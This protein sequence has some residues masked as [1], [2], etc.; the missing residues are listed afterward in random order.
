M[1][2]P[3]V[4]NQNH[5]FLERARWNSGQSVISE[6]L[7]SLLGFRD[8]VSVIQEFSVCFNNPIKS[9]LSHFY[10]N[11]IFDSQTCESWQSTV[12][13]CSVCMWYLIQANFERSD[14]RNFTESVLLLGF[15]DAI[16]INCAIV[17]I[18][19]FL[20]LCSNHPN[21]IWLQNRKLEGRFLRLRR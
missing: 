6:E 16:S 4:R 9:Q 20:H 21:I 10:V 14:A 18:V 8:N 19:S 17:K 12:L 3:P 15:I 1:C 5:R 2:E 13:L 7:E 11:Y